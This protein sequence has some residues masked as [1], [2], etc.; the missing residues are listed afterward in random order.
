VNWPTLREL[1]AAVVAT[2]TRDQWA[3]VYRGTDACVTPVLSFD[4]AAVHPHNVDRRLYERLDGVL[5]PSPAPRFSRTP[6]RAAATPR[7]E[8][9]E[10]SQVIDGWSAR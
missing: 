7:S 9:L 1:I 5:H 6:A 4:E 8:H 10:L 2:R 3:E